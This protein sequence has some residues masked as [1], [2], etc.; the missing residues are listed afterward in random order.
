M[1][2]VALAARRNLLAAILDTVVPPSGDFPGAGVAAI[3]HVLAAA[4]ASADLGALLSG[5]LDA[6]ERAAPAGASPRSPQPIASACFVASRRRTPSSSR[7]WCVGRTTGTTVIRPSSRSSDSIR[8][9]FIRTAIRSSRST[10]PTSPASPRG[11]G[12][13]RV[14]PLPHRPVHPGS[15]PPGVAVHQGRPLWFKVVDDVHAM[16][17]VQVV[18]SAR[19]D[20]PKRRPVAVSAGGATRQGRGGDRP[21]GRRGNPRCRSAGA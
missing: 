9:P 16:G 5:G 13:S 11:D 7:P 17:E 4:A 10:C 15:V 6:T 12:S 21:S 19:P 20:E 1:T 3:D 14:V 18:Y 2:A 8:A